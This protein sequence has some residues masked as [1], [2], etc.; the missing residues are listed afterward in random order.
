M[1]LDRGGASPCAL[2]SEKDGFA[3]PGLAEDIGSPRNPGPSTATGARMP[4]LGQS[5]ARIATRRLYVADNLDYLRSLDSESVDLIVTDPPFANNDK[6]TKGG[7]VSEGD[8]LDELGW[9]R[10]W[11]IAS[12]ADAA[13]GGVVFPSKGYKNVF[14]PA[15]IDHEGLMA[16][17]E[18]RNKTLH[19]YLDR[20]VSP[21]LYACAVFLS[22]R[23]LEM[24]RV[25]K[26]T[27]TLYLHSDNDMAATLELV[28]GL[29]F[30]REPKSRIAWQRHKGYRVVT[31]RF[32]AYH[33]TIL[34]FT[35]S[36]AFT[37]NPQFMPVSEEGLDKNYKY[38]DG[39]GRYNSSPLIT[40]GTSETDTSL[41]WRG[42]DPKANG[43]YWRLP[44]K[45]V[46]HKFI[47]ERGLVPG[48]P[49]AYATTQ[50]KLDALDAAGLIHWPEKSKPTPRLKTYLAASEA[51]GGGGSAPVPDVITH[52]NRLA[53]SSEENTGYGFKGDDGY[54]TQKPVALCEIFVLASSGAGDL[55]LD[56]FSGSGAVAVAA[57]R[58]GRRWLACDNNIR[59]WTMLK[60][61]F[62]KDFL[63]G[64]KTPD[65]LDD[66]SHALDFATSRTTDNLARAQERNGFRAP[67]RVRS[68]DPTA[69]R[70]WM[71]RQ[72]LPL[73]RF[74]DDP[75]E[76][77]GRAWC[78]G[79]PV[80]R[81]SGPLVFAKEIALGHVRP[82]K[83]GGRD[84]VDNRMPLCREHSG[85]GDNLGKIRLQVMARGEL[86]TQNLG[87]LV[88]EDEAHEATLRAFAYASAAQDELRKA[89]AI[90]RPENTTENEAET[91]GPVSLLLA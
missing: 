77:L 55:V 50:E 35:K 14:N 70:D 43:H 71:L 24:H 87:L 47:V 65:P 30:D 41:P 7:A 17:I 11:G 42:I 5:N 38:E 21:G 16:Q 59:S 40:K 91:E 69:E 37:F 23:L 58:N 90:A 78:C 39:L 2:K 36:D 9:L 60:R 82:R 79:L 8:L 74:V 13:Y 12:E 18:F 46:M 48:W 66:P 56:P 80:Y 33:D 76:I 63:F 57:E 32:P 26:R 81:T 1:N 73:C 44:L 45:G 85:L 28:L 34:V 3:G 54:P 67:G 68:D 86:A 84:T 61:Q 15:S 52:I 72:L 6:T 29:V 49:D 20:F 10:K 75:P 25:L 19:D 4:R 53:P 22:A 64:G 89:R 83:S 51:Y 62:S 31:E 27:G 88:N